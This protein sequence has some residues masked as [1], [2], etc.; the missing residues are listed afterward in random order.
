MICLALNNLE[1]TNRDVLNVANLG[2]R[3][4]PSRRASINRYALSLEGNAEFPGC[5][6]FGCEG[7]LVDI[8]VF[9]DIITLEF[10]IFS[11]CGL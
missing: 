8:E 11:I 2:E 5:R 3:S 1:L 10:L 9:A 4:S 7:V 6:L